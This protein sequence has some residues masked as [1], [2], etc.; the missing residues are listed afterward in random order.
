MSGLRSLDCLRTKPAERRDLVSRPA[1]APGPVIR[2]SMRPDTKAGT[3]GMVSGIRVAAMPP[4]CVRAPP[5]LPELV[6]PN[7]GIHS[8]RIPGPLPHTGQG[9]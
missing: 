4:G 9:P 6:S 5:H 2:M 1:R 3:V 7:S 8:A